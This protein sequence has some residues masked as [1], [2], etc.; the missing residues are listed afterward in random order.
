MPFKRIRIAIGQDIEK[1]YPLLAAI[2]D[3]PELA[4]SVQELFVD[5]MAWYIRP[6]YYPS[7]GA[8]EVP[9]KPISVNMATHARLQDYVR[10]I[11]LDQAIAQQMLDALDW[12][13]A[14]G[15]LPR[16]ETGPGPD[17]VASTVTVL[18]LS[19]CKHISVL[20]GYGFESD[21]I[22]TEFLLKNNYNLLP[23]PAL[24]ELKHVRIATA[25]PENGAWYDRAEV[26][27]HLRFF[28]RLPAME[29]LEEAGVMEYQM[30]RGTAPPGTSNIRKI[31]LI[32]V[33]ISSMSIAFMIR[34]ARKLDEFK[35]SLGGLSCFD[36]AS[37]VLRIKTLGKAL[38]EHKTTLRSLE[39]DLETGLNLEW[40]R[41]SD[42]DKEDTLE[43]GEDNDDDIDSYYRLDEAASN[44]RPLWTEHLPNTR[45][46]GLTMGSLHDLESMTHLAIPIS[47]L[48]GPS[49]HPAPFRLVDALPPN[50]T[51]LRLYGYE[52]G[53]DKVHDEHVDELQEQLEE[54]FPLLAEL[55]GV[56]EPIILGRT[57]RFGEPRS[58]PTREEM[59]ELR[60][61]FTLDLG[62]VEA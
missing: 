51:W 55:E 47:A 35:L 54:R 40:K 14:G 58:K 31:H 15:L 11:G 3:N 28:G 46:Y 56:E 43:P 37:S 26:L 8:P 6:Y 50:L 45:E 33:D 16:D 44:N 9:A 61:S 34:A 7:F 27:E 19:L 21:R 12:K 60:E 57:Q 25:H 59:E 30:E 62:W 4:L 32:H 20:H 24:Q 49:S 41:T 39:L 1:C 42:Y 52:R 13:I 38:L 5:T 18:L 22:I 23:Q 48:L 53:S 29:F 2:I 17:T 36:S 10:G